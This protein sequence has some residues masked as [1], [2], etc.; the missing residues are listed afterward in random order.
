MLSDATAALDY[1]LAADVLDAL[2][3]PGVDAEL[4]LIKQRHQTE[5]RQALREA[6]WE[7]NSGPTE[8]LR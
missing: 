5:F 8:E 4:D 1:D 2:P 3:A 7:P 6:G